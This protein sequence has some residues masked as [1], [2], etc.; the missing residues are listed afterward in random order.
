M[1][2]KFK[3][4]RYAIAVGA[5]CLILGLGGL[6]RRQT[7]VW[8]D[9]EALCEAARDTR[10]RVSRLALTVSDA[11]GYLVALMPLTDKEE[12]ERL[13]GVVVDMMADNLK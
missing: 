7:G 3:R 2:N 6:T 11:W 5:A 8:K 9:T 1:A 12:R 10:D 13:L 4:H